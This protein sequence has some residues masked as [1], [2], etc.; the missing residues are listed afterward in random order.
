[1][2]YHWH[3]DA[4]SDGA[5]PLAEHCRAAVEAGLRDLCV[6]NH[7]EVLGA[8]GEWTVAPEEAV[9]R[10]RSEMAAADAARERWPALR[11]R[12]GAEFEYRPGW[13]GPLEALADELPLDFV[14]GSVHVVDGLNV[15]GGDQPRVY[16][17]ERSQSEAYRRYFE[18]VRE[19]VAWG[20]FDVVGHF[21]LIK[22]YGHG[23]YG[24]YDP[25][26]FEGL[27]RDTLDAMARA[28]IGIEV[29]TSGL[30]QAPGAPYPDRRILA[31]AREAG[32]PHLTVGSDSHA[33]HRIAQ[34]LDAGRAAA[35]AAGWETATPFRRGIPDGSVP[36]DEAGSA[37]PPAN[38]GEEIADGR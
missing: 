8:G 25:R 14:I 26:G 20:R 22:R 19:M 37:V 6:T 36:L 17:S 31:W 11:L 12:V 24:S 10:F 5:A 4:S 33:P 23:V 7:V 30:S 34:G 32:V 38:P 28:G 27:I 13:T 15:S 21:D 35:R 3:D 29:N 9:P 2:N 16:F 1:M 18:T